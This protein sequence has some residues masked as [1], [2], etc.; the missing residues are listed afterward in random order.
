MSTTSGREGST[1]GQGGASVGG[2]ADHLDVG[3]GVQ[4]H[5]EA[6]AHQGLVVDDEHPDHVA[7]HPGHGVLCGAV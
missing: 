4:D 2:L 1:Q 3:L 5:P 7:G 6:A